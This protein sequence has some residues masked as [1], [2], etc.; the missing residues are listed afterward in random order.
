MAD[1]IADYLKARGPALSTSIAQHLATT[2]KISPAAARQRVSRVQGQVKKLAYVTFPRGARFMYLQGQFGSA[3]YWGRLVDALLQA[4]SAFGLA[5]ASLVQ[6]NG[7][8]PQAHFEI[9]C[10]APVKQAKHLS[11]DNIFKRLNEAGLVEEISVPGL[12]PCIALVQAAGHYDSRAAEVRVR[13][14]TE[15]LLLTAVR[16]WVRKLGLV[17]YD[18]VASRD[19][20]NRPMVGTFAWDLTAPSYLGFLVKRGAEGAPKPGFFACDIY[21]GGSVSVQ[22]VRPFINKCKTLRQLRNV[23]PCMVMFIA[24]EYTPEAFELLKT[25]GII[26][27]T[28]RNL[29]GDEVGLGLVE[30]SS[31]LKTAADYSIDPVRFDDLFKKF[32]RIEGAAYQLRGTLFEYLAADIVRKTISAQVRMNRIFRSND[33]QKSAEA[34]VY[35]VRDDRAVTFIECKGHSPYGTV[36]DQEMKRWLQHNTP[37]IYEA[38]RAHPDWKNLEIRFEFWSTAPLS[39][40][41]VDMFLKAKDAIK[42]T[43]YTLELRLADDLWKICQA[44]MDSGLATAFQK[45][46]MRY[47]AKVAAEAKLS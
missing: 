7:F 38:A 46:F 10:G 44:T 30:L 5:I 32:G 34:D 21:L 14:I 39:P 16:D 9:A 31:V 42:P 47:D 41:A 43:R 17:S 36:P 12:G 8:M 29:F 13:L 15:S 45:H 11:P 18:K 24:H 35:A 6:R 40:D 19:D 33:G 27:A 3:Q 22:G 25:N 20:G 2:L 4:N 23:A 37:V 1:L 28:P 26:P